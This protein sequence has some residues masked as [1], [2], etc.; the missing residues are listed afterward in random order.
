MH[1]ASI[2]FIFHFYFSYALAHTPI[3]PYLTSEHDNL[4]LIEG[5]VDAYNGKL[6]QIDKDIEIQGS[7]PL[8]LIR[9][10]DGGHHFDSEIGFGVGH[11]FPTQLVF[12][13]QME[14][15]NHFVEQRS[16]A[17]IICSVKMEKKK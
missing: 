13:P 17:N 10:Y 4:S 5:V 15:Q 16:G 8:Q 14:E 12:N 1:K 9:Y 3:V 7:D 2:V 11:S 6:V